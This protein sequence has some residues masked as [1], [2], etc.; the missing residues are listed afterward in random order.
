MDGIDLKFV[1]CLAETLLPRSRLYLE[2]SDLEHD[3]LQSTIG[4]LSLN[5]LNIHWRCAGKIY[6]LFYAFLHT[7]AAGKFR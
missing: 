4:F 3:I 2:I 1:F 7:S 5:L 6:E